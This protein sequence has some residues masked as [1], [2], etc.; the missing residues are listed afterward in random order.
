MTLQAL[1]LDD[2]Q[3]FLAKHVLLTEQTRELQLAIAN[4]PDTPTNLLEILINSSDPLVAEAASH[5]VNWAGEITENWHYLA[6]TT[7]QT[8]ELGQNDRLAVELLKIAPVPDYFLSEFVPASYLSL[9][10]KN[11]HLPLRYR[12]KYL[13]RLAQEPELQPRLEVAECPET[14]V[15]MLEILARDLELPVRMAVKSNPITVPELIELVEEQLAVAKDWNTDAEQLTT[16][17]ESRWDLIRLAVA[18]NPQTPANVLALL[19][20]HSAVEIK[21][22]VAR[23]PHATESILHQLFPTQKDVLRERKN[24]PVSILERFFREAATDEPIWKQY[25]LQNLFLRQLNTPTWIL[26]ELT[27]VDIEAVRAENEALEPGYP[28]IVETLVQDDISFLYDVAKH[29]Q[30]SVEILEGLSD[31]IHPDVQLAV[32]QNSRTP[33]LLRNQIL[34]RLALGDDEGVVRAIAR[35][36]ETPVAILERLISPATTGNQVTKLAREIVPN[37]SEDLLQKIINFVNKYQSPQRIL[38][39]LRDENSRE[40]VFEEWRQLLAGLN[41]IDRTALEVLCKGMLPGIGFGFC[42]GLPGEDRW[43]EKYYSVTSGEFY[44]YGLLTLLGLATENTGNRSI[45]LA[46]L[47]NPNTPAPLREEL[48]EQLINST[49]KNPTDVVIELSNIAILRLG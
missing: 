38:N 10:L 39:R 49:N 16:L 13:E 22:A 20:E 2:L 44:L 24:L 19:A 9:A 1:N 17:G 14:P 29:P 33:E 23:H 21:S 6:D 3:P 32:A 35:S 18:Q 28:E 40:S 46:L 26:A 12:V 25:D 8:K 7:L 47:S 30:V 48:K 15:A 37:I 36:P 41:G 27:N 42:G 5:H 34:L 45:A 31:C 11:P 43:L 4:Y